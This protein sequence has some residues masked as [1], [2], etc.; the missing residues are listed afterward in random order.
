ML[1]SE[2]LFQNK[3]KKS[4]AQFEVTTLSVAENWIVFPQY[5]SQDFLHGNFILLGSFKIQLY[6]NDYEKG[7]TG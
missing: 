6:Y 3:Q 4:L 7:K 5:L 1:L 2:H